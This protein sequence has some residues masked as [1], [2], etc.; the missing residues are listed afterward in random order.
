MK[1]RKLSI[2]TVSL[3]ITSAGL[4]SCKKLVE[5][6]PEDVL[7][8]K[9]A[10]QNIYDANAAVIVAYGKLMNLAGNSF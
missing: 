4:F 8:V 1:L 7:D 3:A 5:V 2:F 10:Y 6:T 9:N